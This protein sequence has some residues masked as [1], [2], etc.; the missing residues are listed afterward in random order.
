VRTLR[1]A[2][3][4]LFALIAWVWSGGVLLAALAWGVGLRCD[5]SCGG[6]GWR[7]SPDGWQWDAVVALGVLGF[8]AGM[9][10]VVFV[11]RG[12]RVLAA[13][14]FLV[15]LGAVLTLA[16]A[17]SPEW[18]EHVDSMSANEAMVFLAGLGAPVAA[19]LLSARGEREG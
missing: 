10:L 4:R 3:A 19:V 17:L 12:R 9:I 1:I 18:P 7:R 16:T 15:G 5:E 11:W 6:P 14:A 13:A 8:L 2:L